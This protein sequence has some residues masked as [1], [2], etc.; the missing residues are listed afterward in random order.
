[1]FLSGT[2]R[3]LFSPN[4][5]LVFMKEMLYLIENKNKLVNRPP[6]PEEE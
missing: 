1:M 3:P 2:L 6:F 5:P 4:C